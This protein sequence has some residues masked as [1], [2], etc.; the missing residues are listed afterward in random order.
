MDTQLIKA[1]LSF[2]I[3]L[4]IALSVSGASTPPISKKAIPSTESSTRVHQVAGVAIQ[5]LELHEPYE[6]QVPT[7]EV[8]R[9]DVRVP[10]K[11][12]ALIAHKNANSSS[13]SIVKVFI[14]SEKSSK[15]I[16]LQV[17]S[18]IDY[19]QQD[20]QYYLSVD[21]TDKETSKTYKA[22]VDNFPLED[23]DVIKPI[24]YVYSTTNSMDFDVVDSNLDSMT[25]I[26]VESGDKKETVSHL[27]AC[28]APL[29]R[30]IRLLYEGSQNLCEAYEL[31][32]PGRTCELVPTSSSVLP[33]PTKTSS[34]ITSGAVS[35]MRN[36]SSQSL[37]LLV[38]V[39]IVL[40]IW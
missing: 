13:T 25:S 2:T 39:A 22:L 8:S 16:T 24:P 21:V 18:T 14:S 10:L 27:P 40:A 30:S 5:C 26:V 31:K 12:E 6:G 15:Q 36:A 35:D 37:L 34:P 38:I 20:G 3:A 11:H 17:G 9:M 1:L 19:N 33:T 23:T 4:T 29:K 28:K 7:T 32:H